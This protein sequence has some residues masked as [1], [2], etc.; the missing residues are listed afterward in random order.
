MSAAIGSIFCGPLHTSALRK[1][2]VS[3]INRHAQSELDST[4][5]LSLLPPLT[6]APSLQQSRPQIRRPCAIMRILSSGLMASRGVGENVSEVPAVSLRAV[7]SVRAIQRWEAERRAASP[8][9]PLP[10]AL[11]ARRPSA[12]LQ[13]A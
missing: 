2:P 5:L 13:R 8:S 7:C 11:I 12:L 6:L 9:N 3:L 1:H 10:H 4:L